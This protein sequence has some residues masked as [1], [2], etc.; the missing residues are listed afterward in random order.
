MQDAPCSEAL[1]A[2]ADALAC[3]IVSNRSRRQLILKVNEQTAGLELKEENLA[4]M[5]AQI[6]HLEFGVYHVEEPKNGQGK[7]AI[8]GAWGKHG[9]GYALVPV[10][11]V[12]ERP[13]LTL[14]TRVCCSNNA[15]LERTLGTYKK[16]S[17]LGEIFRFTY[18]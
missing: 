9:A 2:Q 12:R 18:I 4:H 15:M 14:Y 11:V 17:T 1:Q 7:R 13:R 16:G 3:M 5:S 8:R 6:R 10:L